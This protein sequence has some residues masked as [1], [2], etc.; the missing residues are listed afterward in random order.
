MRT[1]GSCSGGLLLLDEGGEGDAE[2]M[3]D[4]REFVECERRVFD[5]KLR[6]IS[7]KNAL[8]A[9]NVNDGVGWGGGGWC[10]GRVEAR[11]S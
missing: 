8:V 2:V 3:P 7:P 1:A 9:A 11:K 4:G 6:F 5:S 10:D